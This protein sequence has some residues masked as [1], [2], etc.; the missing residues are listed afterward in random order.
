MAARAAG[1]VVVALAFALALV[2][3]SFAIGTRGLAPSLQEYTESSE[4][5]FQPLVVIAGLTL[6]L[7]LLT[8]CVVYALWRIGLLGWAKFRVSS[9]RRAE[10]KALENHGRKWLGIRSPDDEAIRGLTSTTTLGGKVAPRFGP[11]S[12]LAPA[13]DQFFWDVLRRKVQGNDL[14]GMY[15]C[16]V[17]VG[18]SPRYEFPPLDDPNLLGGEVN[19]RVL[20]RAASEAP[21]ALANFRRLLGLAAIHGAEWPEL[22]LIVEQEGLTWDSLLV[23]TL[24]LQIGDGH[25]ASIE[26]VGKLLAFHILQERQVITDSRNYDGAQADSATTS[27]RLSLDSDDAKL[28]S[29]LQ[30]AKRRLREDNSPARS[31][32]HALGPESQFLARE[33]HDLLPPVAAPEAT[34]NGEAVGAVKSE[35]S[36]GVHENGPDGRERTRRRSKFRP[37]SESHLFRADSLAGTVAVLGVAVLASIGVNLPLN[38]LREYTPEYQIE[39]MV[40]DTTNRDQF[41]PHA[42]GYQWIAMLAWLGTGNGKCDFD[43][44]IAE[45][46]AFSGEHRARGLRE[47]AHVAVARG[48]RNELI[49]AVSQAKYSNLLPTM[50]AVL[51]EEYLNLRYDV[52]LMFSVK[53]VS[54][55]P[56]AGRK[57]VVAADVDHVLHFRIF[58]DDARL[59][60]ET[61]EKAIMGKAEPLKDLRVQLEKLARF[62]PVNRERDGRDHRGCHIDCRLPPA[63]SFPDGGQGRGPRRLQGCMHRAKRATVRGPRLSHSQHAPLAKV[64]LTEDAQ[65]AA[66]DLAAALS[67]GASTSDASADIYA[68]RIAID[69][70][71]LL[72][73]SV[74]AN[75]YKE[76]LSRELPTIGL[77]QDA[78]HAA[79]FLFEVG[80]TLPALDVAFWIQDAEDRQSVLA[81]M[82]D[83]PQT[84]RDSLEEVFNLVRSSMKEA[85]S[86]AKPGKNGQVTLVA[87]ATASA[88]QF[89]TWT[90]FELS[91]ALAHHADWLENSNLRE[92]SL[93]WGFDA[94]RICRSTSLRR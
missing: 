15:L 47:I 27:S 41:L 22:K 86:G 26:P 57:L 35:H 1:K 79:E 40:E 66:K 14:P 50:H 51:A 92:E 19:K 13:G 85:M 87:S 71:T 34:A 75:G 33:H 3:V 67:P 91:P 80:R 42:K 20:A 31:E 59:V 39:R 9:D 32:H 77:G 82:F 89:H 10:H 46:A 5:I 21:E 62:P 48:R 49:A 17:G 56:T 68:M 16:R 24:Y 73:D 4:S 2:L 83:M 72:D 93:T 28:W 64:G 43:R 23:H 63:S 6:L 11:V 58:D 12:L 76:R 37:P 29:W 65:N 7:L 53:H 36:G 61:D 78:A 81:L 54:G 30:E 18:P 60:V 44:P 55:M 88:S 45:V 38:R 69:V 90:L 94:L 70:S 52:R 8:S 74:S 84:K 25:D